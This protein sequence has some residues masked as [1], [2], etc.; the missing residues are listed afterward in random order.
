MLCLFCIACGKEAT[1][2]TL[3]SPE[4]TGVHF[5][6]EIIQK[7]SFNIMQNEYMYNGGGVGIADLN[8]DGLQDIIFTGNTVMSRIYLNRGEMKFSDI[9]DAFEGL[10]N[11]QWLSGVVV[12]DINADGWQDLYFTS[13]MSEDSALRKNQLWINQGLSGG[14]EV[15]RF[16]EMA[17][18]YGIADEGYSMHAAFFD[19]DLDGDLDLYVLNN[20]VSKEIPTNFRPK[21]TDG[22]AI[23]NDRLYKNMGD[24][25][26]EDV[27]LAAGIVFEGYGLGLAVGDLNHDAYPD[28]YVSNDYISN[29]LLYINQRDGTF[30]NTSEEYLSY[31]S[32][33]SMGSDM[34]DINN[35]GFLDIMTLDMFP[36]D[37]CRKKQTINGN[38]Y[39]IY[40]YNEQY[41]Y[42]PQFVRNMLHVHNGL[43]HGELL[44]FSE[45]GQLAGIYQTEWSWSS[46]FA[47]YDNDGDKDLMVTNGFPKDLTDKDFT[48][49][50]AQMYGYLI[51]DEEIIPRIPVVKVSNYAYENTGDLT[52]VNRT[53]EWGMDL[54]SFSNGAA[55]A[56]LDNDGDLDYVV[57]NINDIAFIYRN[58]TCG[59]KGAKEKHIR[60]ALKGSGLN[61]MAIGAKV[62]IWSNDLYQYYEHHLTRGYLSSVDPVIHFG[63]GNH[64]LIDSLKVSWPGDHQVTRLSQVTANQLITLDQ[65]DAQPMQKSNTVSRKRN[66]TL[67]T[68]APGAISYTHLQDDYNDFFQQQRIIQHKFSQVGPCMSK[69]D[70][71]GDGHEDLVIAGSNIQPATVYLFKG[72]HFEETVIPGL[73]GTR[74]CL[75]SDLA[76]VDI[77]ND[78]KSDLVALAGGYA[79]EKPEDYRHSIYMNS[80]GTFDAV[81]LPVPAFPASVVRSCDFDKDGDMDLFVGARVERG[82]FPHAPKSYVLMNVQGAFS[83]KNRIAFDLGMVTD[84]VW[85]DTDG[86]GWQDLLIAREWNSIALLH[87]KAGRDFE[88]APDPT[89]DKEHGF[90]SCIVAADL[91]RDGDDDYIAGNLG[92]NHR[93]TI[94]ETYPMKLYAVDVDH[95][96][97]IDPITAS[98]WKDREGRMQEYPVNYLDELAAQSPFFRKK[99][100]SYTQFSYTSIDSILDRQAIPGEQILTVNTSSSYVI[101]NERDGFSWQKLPKIVQASPVKKVL[102]HDFNRDQFPDILIAGN[103]YSFDVSTGYYDANKGIVLIGSEDKSFTVLPASQSGL[104]LNGQVE[105]LLY[106]G[107]DTAWIIAGINRREIAVYRIT[108]PGEL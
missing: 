25:H 57:H 103:D 46:L 93:F 14:A 15:P 21:I 89:F 48:N 77:N 95:N 94:N 42:Q 63:I 107:G 8:N 61:T 84:A 96:G 10:T 87:N 76:V 13:T 16:K 79:N 40:K 80:S 2:F 108:P 32:R 24:G 3:L 83:E 78:G 73:S 55:F 102:I 62:E 11:T 6:N 85:S 12:V 82:N 39:L 99:F 68:Q 52:F 45:V 58:N 69:G 1:R 56:D 35:D 53:K 90:W 44:P 5:N 47:D 86:D 23:N 91:D 59:E 7:D 30:R 100:T 97:V 66:Q 50:K 22:S 105:S 38:S 101:W 43:L 9:T 34:A 27:T 60:I 70:I 106:F 98:F 67:F 37:Y 41:G 72:D 81:P 20:I 18:Q 28:I 71:D 64:E 17:G 29:D 74:L 49:Y 33:F 75:E 51:G 104:I 19:Y 92:D 65:A 36:E 31:H 54:P 26:F 4:S 88:I